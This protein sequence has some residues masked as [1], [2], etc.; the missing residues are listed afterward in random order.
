MDEIDEVCTKNPRDFWKYIKSLGPTRKNEIP[1]KVRVG[2]DL[3][4]EEKVVLAK[5]GEEFEKL[6]NPN[7][8]INFD[9]QLYKEISEIISEK[10]REMSDA[11][12]VENVE[13]NGE[14]LMEELSKMSQKLK[15][16][17]A[18]GVDGIPNEVL[19]NPNVM[20]TL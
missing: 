8:N 4:T 5:W 12:Y 18:C 15:K 20:T 6:Y 1:M 10:E 19:R 9:A 17:K 7:P 13:I 11:G 16:N 2:D 14:I 3:I